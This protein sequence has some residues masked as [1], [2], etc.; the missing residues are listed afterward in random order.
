MSHRGGLGRISTIENPFITADNLTPQKARI[1]LILA[2]AK[3]QAKDE[4]KRI[5]QTH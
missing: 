1:L 3:T 5:V 2:L 4:L